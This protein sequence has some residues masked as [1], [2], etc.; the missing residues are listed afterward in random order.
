MLFSAWF[1]VNYQVRLDRNTCD[2][3]IQTMSPLCS[4]FER[5]S[6]TIYYNVIAQMS[7]VMHIV[8]S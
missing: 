6:T 4:L 1:V 8:N 2:N 7:V 5:I 3:N